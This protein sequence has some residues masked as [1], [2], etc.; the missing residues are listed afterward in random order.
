MTI[1]LLPCAVPPLLPPL[2]SPISSLLFPLLSSPSRTV[3]LK[4]FFA[5]VC[6]AAPLCYG[7]VM[8][9]SQSYLEFTRQKTRLLHG[10]GGVVTRLI[11]ADRR[12]PVCEGHSGSLRAAA[13]AHLPGR[14][15]GAG[16]RAQGRLRAWRRSLGGGV[17]SLPALLPGRPS[18][19]LYYYEFVHF[20]M[21][22]SPCAS[23][24]SYVSNASLQAARDAVVIS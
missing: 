20:L 14:G 11:A 1:L 6:V 2:S 4:S 12:I 24:A 18:W 13:R 19:L 16:G 15:G 3:S 9:T 23:L 10:P 5:R 17:G 22:A 21:W 8:W 7:W